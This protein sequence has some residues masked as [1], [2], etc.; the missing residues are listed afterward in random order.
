MFKMVTGMLY[1]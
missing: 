1:S